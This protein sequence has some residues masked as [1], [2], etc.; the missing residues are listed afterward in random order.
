MFKYSFIAVIVSGLMLSACTN[1]QQKLAE[2][3]IIPPEATA[4]EAQ[5]TPRWKQVDVASLEQAF[6]KETRTSAQFPAYV[7][8]LKLKAAQLG[9][10]PETI[11]FAFSEAH[12]IERVIKSDRNQPEKRITLDVYLPRIVTNGRLSQGAKLYQEHQDTLEQISKNMV[13]LLTILLR[14]GG[15]RVASVKCKV[16]RM[17]FLHLQRWHLKAVEKR[18]LLVN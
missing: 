10:K 15:L 14:Y 13:C 17:L 8:A 16:K 2:R 6:P 3:Q 9:Y 5:K 1:S 7:D 18:C 12:F 4:V 11:D